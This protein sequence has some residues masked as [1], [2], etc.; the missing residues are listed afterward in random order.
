MHTLIFN[1]GKNF[2]NIWSRICQISKEHDVI[3][4]FFF[5]IWVLRPIKIISLILRSIVMWG[6]KKM[7]DP[8]EKPIDHPQAELGLSHMWPELGLNPQR[9]DDERFRVLKI[10]VLNHS[11]MRATCYALVMGAYCPLLP[12]LFFVNHFNVMK[13]VCQKLVL[14]S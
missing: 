12:L 7:G 13:N 6:E 4:T 1:F 10:S 5:L 8:R 3:C 11:A 2:F 9:W 14:C